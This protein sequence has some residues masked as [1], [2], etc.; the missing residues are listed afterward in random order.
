MDATQRKNIISVARAFGRN[1]ALLEWVE[2]KTVALEIDPTMK[3][4]LS[5]TLR[6][7]VADLATTEDLV[8]DLLS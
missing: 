7:I 8:F 3:E 2:K 6:G 5:E 4:V 1:K